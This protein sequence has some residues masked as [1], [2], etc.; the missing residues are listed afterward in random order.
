MTQAPSVP[1]TA[2]S[3]AL[4]SFHREMTYHNAYVDYLR[5]C[6][7]TNQGPQPYQFW[8]GRHAQIEEAK[9]KIAKE[10]PKPGNC[11]CEFPNLFFNTDSRHSMICP[12]QREYLDRMAAAAIVAMP[13]IAGDGP[14]KAYSLLLGHRWKDHGE[15]EV[16]ACECCGLEQPKEA[17]PGE[18]ATNPC[19]VRVM[20]AIP[21]LIGA[22][23]IGCSPLDEL[24]ESNPFFRKV[25][26]MVKAMDDLLPGFATISWNDVFGQR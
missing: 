26:S 5:E 19:P 6:E 2:I 25:A 16:T 7:R 15:A 22:M 18:A 14:Y 9:E 13:F 11:T 8:R 12:A 4:E 24:P 23:K 3:E 17:I 20:K 1:P 10:N 21:I